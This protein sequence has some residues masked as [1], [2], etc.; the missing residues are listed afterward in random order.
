MCYTVYSVRRGGER[1]YR[2]ASAMRVPRHPPHF[3]NS[4]APTPLES[5]LTKKR[6]VPLSSQKSLSAA[7]PFVAAL[8]GRSQIIEKTAIL[9]PA[10]ATL[11]DRVKPK[12]FPCHSYRK[13]PGWGYPN[14]PTFKPSNVQTLFPAPTPKLLA[15]NPTEAHTKE[16][17]PCQKALQLQHKPNPPA[18]PLPKL[19][20]VSASTPSLKFP[21]NSGRCSPTPSPSI[22]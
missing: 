22:S 21:R 15:S 5:A 7:S 11:T 6:G 2:L 9:S 18:K 12:S 14:V 4:L 10:F 3:H 19:R 16:K 8:V 20:T 17:K 1:S 13:H